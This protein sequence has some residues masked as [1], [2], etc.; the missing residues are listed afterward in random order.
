MQIT[1]FLSEIVLGRSVYILVEV[2]L[3][4]PLYITSRRRFGCTRLTIFTVLSEL[5]S[6]SA[7][8]TVCGQFS[9]TVVC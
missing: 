6:K 3:C 8:Q 5:K 1:S 4:L 2:L 9:F 7:Y